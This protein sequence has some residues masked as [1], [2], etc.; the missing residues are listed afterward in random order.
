MKTDL[1]LNL[2]R[3]HI[4]LSKFGWR[5]KYTFCINCTKSSKK[6][7]LWSYVTTEFPAE[8]FDLV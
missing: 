3:H 5:F 1:P 6:G 8:I 4:N 7:D 2:A